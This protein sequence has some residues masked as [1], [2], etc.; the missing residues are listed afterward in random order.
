MKSADRGGENPYLR[1]PDVQRMLRAK[2]GEQAAFAELVSRH[3]D[4]VLRVGWHLLQSREMAED[5]V[6]EVFLRIYRARHSYEP[7]SQFT[8]WMFRILNNLVL[9]LRRD[10]ARG[11]QALAKRIESAAVSVQ[12][13]PSSA[14]R[15]E[16]EDRSAPAPS[17]PLETLELRGAVRAAL[18]MLTESQRAAMLLRTSD[19]LSYAEI[20]LVLKLTPTAV[21]SLLS[22]ARQALHARLKSYVQHGVLSSECRVTKRSLQTLGGRPCGRRPVCRP[23]VVA[24]AG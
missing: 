24:R 6:Q 18:G 4:H 19:D 13:T 20:A 7:H 23:R 12:G 5:L 17:Q 10:A 8:T 22:R 11:R 2:A 16:I 9:N 21:K 1:D 15:P 3:R 14:G